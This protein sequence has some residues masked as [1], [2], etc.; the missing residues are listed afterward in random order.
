MC[1]YVNEVEHVLSAYRKH[2]EQ[3]DKKKN[4]NALHAALQ[5]SSENNQKK[6]CHLKKINW[7]KQIIQ[8]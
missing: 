3:V 2:T 6:N 7:I 1:S 4:S 5:V 8:L